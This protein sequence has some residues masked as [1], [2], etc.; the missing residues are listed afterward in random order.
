M[1]P[2]MRFRTLAMPRSTSFWRRRRWSKPRSCA[3]RPRARSRCPKR[4]ARYA[5]GEERA[6]PKQSSLFGFPVL[7]SGVAVRR[8]ETFGRAAAAVAVVAVLVWA[9]QSIGH[10]TVMIY[11]GLGRALKVAVGSQ[12]VDVPAFGHQQVNVEDNAR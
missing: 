7:L 11:N 1:P 3:V 6:L 9:G 5:R 2:S 12:S 4:F 8:L 10:S